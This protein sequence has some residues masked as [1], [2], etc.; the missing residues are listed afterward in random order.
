MIIFYHY[1]RCILYANQSI[2][3]RIRRVN[4]ELYGIERQIVK[5]MFATPLRRLDKN[6]LKM[7]FLEANYE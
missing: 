7:L 6:T 1:V 4:K 3:I 2:H 5:K